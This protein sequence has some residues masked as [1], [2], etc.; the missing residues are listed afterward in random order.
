M[1][2]DS[3]DEP[4]RADEKASGGSSEPAHVPPRPRPVTRWRRAAVRGKAIWRRMS[5]R[6]GV[7]HLVR[8]VQRAG[9]AMRGPMQAQAV[10]A[11]ILKEEHPQ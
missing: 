7:A 10:E 11:E 8:A 1:T 6:P 9:Q 3:S 4:A 2:E 5:K